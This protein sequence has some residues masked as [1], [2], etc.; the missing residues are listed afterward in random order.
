MHLPPVPGRTFPQ[1]DRQQVPGPRPGRPVRITS[2]GIAKESGRKGTLLA[3]AGRLPFC[4]ATAEAAA[5]DDV[6]FA[7]RRLDWAANEMVDLPCRVDNV[8]ACIPPGSGWGRDRLIDGHTLFPYQLRFAPAGL[9]L[10]CAATW[11]GARAGGPPASGSCRLPS[12][13]GNG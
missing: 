11:P 5:E 3:N 4:T 10:R 7:R 9:P 1:R 8:V 2:T 13:R 12:R 6:L